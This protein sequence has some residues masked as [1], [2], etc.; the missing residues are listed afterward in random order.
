MPSVP[1]V[2]KFVARYAILWSACCVFIGRDVKY[3]ATFEERLQAVEQ[4]HAEIKQ[5]NARLKQDNAELRQKIELQTI[6]IGGLVNKTVLDQVNNKNDKIFQT[7]MRHDEFT[8]HELAEIR[9]D[10]SS[11]DGKTVGLQTEMRTSI[12]RLDGKVVGLQ[13]EMRQNFAA[14]NARFETVDTNIANIAQTLT[15]MHQGFAAVNARFE[16]VDTS[17]AQILQILSVLTQKPDQEK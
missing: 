8:N 16:A 11:L 7:L 15:E 13:T 9:M 4:D 14:V 6:A 1:T 5:D 3:M 2:S 17:L 10:I 12:S